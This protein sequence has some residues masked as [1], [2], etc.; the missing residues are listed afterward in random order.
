MII[1]RKCGIIIRKRGIEIMRK[2]LENMTVAV[3]GIGSLGAELCK[4]IAE[5]GAKRLVLID[6]YENNLYKVARFLNESYPNLEV[7][8]YVA[9]ICN[10]LQMEKILKMEKV[11]FL[12]HTAA[13]KH[14]PLMEIVPD[15]AVNNNILGT[16][17]I[18][19][20]S[21]DLGCEKVVLIS[22]D[23]AVEPT[24]VYGA[25]KRVCE[26]IFYKMSKIYRNT[27][28]ITIR[29]G[30]L[31]GSEGSVV[32][33]F[34][35]Q[36]AAEQDLTVTDP[37]M[38][39]YFIPIKA[40]CEHVLNLIETHETG[41]IFFPEMGEPVNINK[42][43]SDIL[44]ESHKNNAKIIYTGLRNGEKI[45]EKMF[46]NHEKPVIYEKNRMYICDE[47]KLDVGRFDHLL[48]LIRG[49]AGTPDAPDEIRR[50]LREILSCAY[51]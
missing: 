6:I 19:E 4:K 38:T 43:A 9:S 15:E 3:T 17:N 16:Y 23:K 22:T 30:N 48:E 40:A 45:H 5:N 7:R 20:A 13:H 33:L 34:E 31:Y 44:S 39:R 12:I 21:G 32:Q 51:A 50:L 14:V 24:C 28:Y 35:S 2:K 41:K 1:L 47:I 36:L 46:Y 37:R 27:E 11:T 18:A 8:P 29:L 26:M 25:T 49:A 42:I 10:I